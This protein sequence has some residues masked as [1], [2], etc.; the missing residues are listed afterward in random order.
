M[1]GSHVSKVVLGLLSGV[2]FV[3]LHA[4]PATVRVTLPAGSKKAGGKL[5][6]HVENLKL[7]PNSSGIVRVFADAPDANA[8]TSTEDEHFLG[9]FTILAKNSAEASQGIERSSAVLDLSHKQQLLAGK[10]Q[11]T[12]TLVPLGVESAPPAEQAQ[13]KPTFARAYIARN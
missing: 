13:Q 5:V 1:P 3:T 2:L 10:K 12:L 8:E 7:P 11:V 4:A 9:Y 6:L